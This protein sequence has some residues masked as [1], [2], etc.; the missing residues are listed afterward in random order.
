MPVVTRGKTPVMLANGHSAQLQVPYAPLAAGG[1]HQCVATEC[2]RGFCTGDTSEGKPDVEGS[3]GK[4]G[5]TRRRMDRIRWVNRRSVARRRRE[6]TG[7]NSVWQALRKIPR[8]CIFP[9]RGDELL[10]RGKD[11]GL[12]AMQSASKTIKLGFLAKA[13]RH[14]AERG[15][16]FFGHIVEGRLGVFVILDHGYQTSFFRW[17]RQT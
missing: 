11:C 8:S 15:P 5:S 12:K 1:H 14:I 16:L 6:S 2:A 17:Y 13:S 7:A 4:A 10:E 3:R 9:I